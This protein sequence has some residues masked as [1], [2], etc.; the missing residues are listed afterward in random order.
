[1]MMSSSSK[2]SGRPCA[3]RIDLGWASA[4]KGVAEEL[5]RGREDRQVWADGGISPQE[6]RLGRQTA[7]PLCFYYWEREQI[8]GRLDK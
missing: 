5:G 7:S 3:K 6:N 1:M 4:T 2:P 8:Y